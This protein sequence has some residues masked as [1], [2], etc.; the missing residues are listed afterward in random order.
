M[1]KVV[2]PNEGTPRKVSDNKIINNLITN[3]ISSNVSLSV[4]DAT[5][6][7]ERSTTEYDRIYYVLE[8]IMRLVFDEQEQ[9]LHPGDTCFISKSTLYELS[10]TFKAVVIN[11]P[12]F[13]S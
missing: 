1:Y 8:G 3:D 9:T 11:Q 4:I 13:S 6:L 7:Q 2:R 10:G 12:A 5:D